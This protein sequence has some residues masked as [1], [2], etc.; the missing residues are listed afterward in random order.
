MNIQVPYKYTPRSYQMGFFQAM[1]SGIKRAC[2]VWHRKSGKTLSLV[3]FA[4]KMGFTRVGAIYHCFPEYG[5]GRKVVWDGMDNDGNRIID[6][7]VPKEIRQNINNT[8]MKIILLNGSIYQII[9]ADNYDSLVGPNPVG[10][11]LDEWAVSDRYPQA[12]HYFSPI[13]AQNGGWAVFPYTPRGRNHGFDLF[14]KVQGN[15]EWFQQLLT[16]EDT[17]VVPLSAIESDRASGMPESMIRQEYYCDFIAS[18]EDIVIPFHLIQG[19]LRRDFPITNI[20]R[21][22]GVDVARFGDDRTAMVIRQG[23]QIIHVE[24]WKN[25]DAVRVAGKISQMYRTKLFDCVA[26]D[27]IGVGAGVYDMVR[28]YGIPCVAVNVAES[29]S[30]KERFSRLRDELWWNV[31]LWFEDLTCSISSGIPEI[32][33][34]T[35][36]KDIQDIRYKYTNKGLIKIESKDDMKTRLGFS[37]DLGDALCCTFDQGVNYKVRPVDRQFLGRMNPDMGGRTE[38]V[39]DD[40]RFGLN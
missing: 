36:V 12:W 30:E 1:D 20:G 25:L 2:L 22:A 29:S 13:L 32:D 28:N 39:Y 10:L 23:G 16:V 40:L 14:Q 19:A 31:R 21:I 27:V 8:E 11:I 5:Q 4:V 33:R 26:I 34:Q 17:H 6:T 38:R 15:K 24:T 3:N 35:L 37:P 9:G 18:L 7:H